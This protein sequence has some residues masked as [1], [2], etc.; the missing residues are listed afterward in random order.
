V[1]LELVLDGE[2]REVD[3]EATDE[4]TYQVRVDGEPFEVT[5]T[6]AGD[7]VEATAAGRTYRIKRRG[8]SLI[9]DDEPVDV[10]VQRLAQARIGASAAA[11]GEV[12]P[13]MPGQIVEVLVEEGDHV[14]AGEGLLVLEA[15]K[16][17]NEIEAPGASTVTEVRVAEGDAVEASDVL[18]ALEPD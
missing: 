5:V 6:D 11:G 9:V 10:G 7:G 4:G 3:L 12:T 13:P 18:V 2:L 1:S 14:E 8:R 16:M 15:M 17:Q